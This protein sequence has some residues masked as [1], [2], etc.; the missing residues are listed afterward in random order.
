MGEGLCGDDEGK[1]Q[2]RHRIS[3]DCG[4][5]WAGAVFDDNEHRLVVLHARLGKLCEILGVR[6]ASQESSV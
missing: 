4:C 6:E 5:V 1:L 3:Q 2:W